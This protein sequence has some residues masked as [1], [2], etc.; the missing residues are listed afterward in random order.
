MSLEGLREYVRPLTVAALLVV[1]LLGAV[2]AGALEAFS[3]GAGE[4]FTR[5]VAG[6]F[7]AIPDKYYELLVL[8]L[9]GYT[10]GRTV[11]KMVKLKSRVDDPPGGA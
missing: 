1:L 7:N 9:L 5:A 3:P 8:G 4:T 6:W 10:A 11:E 2:V